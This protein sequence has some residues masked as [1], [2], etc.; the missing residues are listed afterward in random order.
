MQNHT[1][2][3]AMTGKGGV[4]K[5]SLSAAMVK[6]LIQAFPNQR[7][8][9]IDADPA[10]GLST[11]LGVE[12]KSTVD[13]IRKE[14]IQTAESGATEDALSMLGNAKYKI[15]E[16]LVELPEFSFLAIGR[17]ESSGCYCK[18]N[19]YLKEIIKI[20][21]DNYDYIV[22]D[23]EAGIEQVNRRVMEKVTHLVLVSDASKKGLQ[24][25]DTIH[26]VAKDLMTYETAGVIINRMP[27]ESVREW[28]SIHQ[29]PV[30]SYIASDEALATCD[31]KG[32]TVLSLS[33]EALIIKGAREALVKM[34]ILKG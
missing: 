8:L 14:F 6:L 9:A 13:D 16:A 24:V 2:I 28:I 26:S 21:A 22:I 19:S 33:E 10:V 5:T 25:I 20:I 30:F 23:G 31:M 7:I 17:P 1:K 4:G 3:I 34:N 12:V 15:F 18:V 27:S 11:A 29:I 32:E